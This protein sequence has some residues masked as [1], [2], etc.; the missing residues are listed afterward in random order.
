MNQSSKL[1]IYKQ[2]M[3]AAGVSKSAAFPPLW[4]L[5][6]RIGIKIPPPVFLGFLPNTLILG[7]FSG[8][9]FAAITSLLHSLGVFDGQTMSAPWRA[10]M[11]GVP[12]G[13]AMAYQQHSLSNK[14][15]LGSWSA[16]PGALSAPNS[17]LKRTNQSLRD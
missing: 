12:F 3:A 13:L 15:S 16:F 6:W 9:I 5:L 7:G 14:H 1:E 4:S 8:V 10:L 17:S 11:F 2:H